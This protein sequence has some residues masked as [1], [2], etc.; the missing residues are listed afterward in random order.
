M[1]VDDSATRPGPVAVSGLAWATVGVVAFSGT[2]PATIF[3]LRGF[4]PLLVGAGRSVIAAAV[5]GAAL[6]IWSRRLPP[7]RAAPFTW[8]GRRWAGCST[9]R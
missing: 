6:L 8:P 2:L 1:K 3:A 5:A 7:R 9:R 4:D